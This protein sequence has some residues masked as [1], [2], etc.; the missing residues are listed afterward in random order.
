MKFAGVF[1]RSDRKSWYINYPHPQTG[2][3]VKEGTP[4]LRGDPQGYRKALD[5]ATEKGKSGLASKLYANG[6]RWET[7]VP[8]FVTRHYTHPKSLVRAE[9]AWKHWRSFLDQHTIP[10]PRALMYQHIVEFVS[11][12]TAQKKRNGS[13]VSKNTAL[14]DLRIMSTIMREAVKLGL[15]GANPCASPGF[16]RDDAKEK[17]EMTDGELARIREKLPAWA[18]ANKE[19]WMPICFEVAIHQGC[20]LRETQLD[21][22]RDVDF[23]RDTITFHLKGG[24]VFATKLHPKLKPQLEMIRDS[25]QRIACKVPMLASKRWREFLDSIECQHLSFHCTRVTVVTKLARA[26]VSEQQ[27]MAYVGHSSELI[28]EV[29]QKLKPADLTAATAALKF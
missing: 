16:K 23:K 22:L 9:G 29:Y 27:A 11:W 2:V 10:V 15:A 24:R 4:F 1:G 6:E 12:R 5:L 14:C 18:E 21:L 20:R 17:N 7:W 13:L 25:G 19:P 26:G 28:H 3:R 8:A